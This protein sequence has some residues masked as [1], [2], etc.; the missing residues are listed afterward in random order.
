M[1]IHSLRAA[2]LALLLLLLLGHRSSSTNASHQ[3]QRQRA[4]WLRDSTD[5]KDKIIELQCLARCGSTTSSRAERE[6]CL[7][8]CILELLR[9]PRAGSCPPLGRQTRPRLSCLDNCVYDHDCADV[10]KC[11]VSACGPVCVDPVGLRNDTELPPIPRIQYFKMSRGHKVELRIESSLLVYYFHLEVRYHIGRFFAPRKLG[12]WQWQK[13]E[14]IMETNSGRSKLT[15]VFFNMRPGRWYQVRVAA[16]NAFGFRGYSQ[17]TRPFS[18][19]GNPKPPKAPNDSK[20]ISKQYDGRFMNAKLVWCPSKSNLPVEK[21]KI[22]WSLYVNSAEASMITQ[23]TYV[24]DSHQF[25]IRKL[26]PNSSYYIQ[27]Q[28]ISYSG[29][30]RLKSDKKSLLFNTTLQSLEAYAPLQCSAHNFRRKYHHHI[31]TT[32]SGSS[33]STSTSTERTSTPVNINEVAPVVNRTTAVAVA[34]VT[35]YDVRFRLNRKFGMIVQ[36]FG[37]QPHK[38][39]VYELCPQETNCEQRE[40]SA[41]RAKKDSLEFSKLKYNTTYVLKALRSSP[42]SVLDETRNVFTFT[43]PKCENFL[44]T[45]P[46]LQMKC[47]GD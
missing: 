10:Q 2:L 16:V 18:S 8:E 34:A 14:K 24:K 12:L 40:F 13:V 3:L 47:S 6:R 11:C 1:E 44:K 22:I 36:I 26:L 27:V 20:I 17:P 42:N 46:K 25:E 9:A 7:D 4:S 35:S 5:I 33:S 15:D 32:S 30:R 37:F 43:T 29:S 39:K 19:A 28:A 21:Y 38:E 31:P 23:D 41:I 45:F